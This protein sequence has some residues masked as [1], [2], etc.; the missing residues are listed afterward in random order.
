[1]KILMKSY[2][3]FESTIEPWQWNKT[4]LTWKLN[5]L[6]NKRAGKMSCSLDKASTGYIGE[7][8][9]HLFSVQMILCWNSKQTTST[10][11]MKLMICDN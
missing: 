11:N 8:D 5:L 1:M 9:K 10:E 2:I 6:I 3:E 4:G 7:L